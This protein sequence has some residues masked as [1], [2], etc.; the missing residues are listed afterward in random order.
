MILST[1]LVLLYPCT[2][3]FGQQAGKDVNEQP[4]PEW[5]GTIHNFGEITRNNPVKAEFTFKNPTM[6]PLVV[7]S[8][9]TS[10]GCTVAGY[11]KNP[12]KPGESAKIVVTYNAKGSGYFKKTVRVNFNKAGTTTTLF[13]EGIVKTEG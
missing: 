10:C 7:T 2:M 8:V 13:I 9:T 12:V 6:D 4:V 11:P 1:L 3:L 5:E